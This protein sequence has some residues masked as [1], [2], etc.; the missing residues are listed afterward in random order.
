[1]YI[2][3]E[4]TGDLLEILRHSG[5]RP[6]KVSAILEHDKNVG[7][8]EHRLGSNAFDARSSQQRRNDWIS[9]LIFD[10]IRWLACPLGVNDYL[11]VADVGKSVQRNVLQAPYARDR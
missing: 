5:T 4:P 6:V 2:G 9:D 10:Y 1:M 3:W 7:I 8:S 11:H